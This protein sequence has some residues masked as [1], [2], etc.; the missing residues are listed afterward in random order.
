MTATAGRQGTFLAGSSEGLPE[1]V[2][3]E[4]GKVV[5]S[6]PATTAVPANDALTAGLDREEG[7]RETVETESTLEALAKEKLAYQMGVK[8]ELRN[9]PGL[10]HASEDV[11]NLAR[12][13]Y[14]GKQGLVVVTDRRVMF[15]SEGIGRHKLEDFPYDKVS[16]VQSEKG[17]VNGGLKIFAS[18]NCATRDFL[19]PMNSNRR[20]GSYSSGSSRPSNVRSLQSDQ[21]KPKALG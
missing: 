16:S 17:M 20:S 2:A 4:I 13:S 11:V 15:L 8:K 7:A 18:V 6:E 21:G 1:L 14:D 9:L 19:R 10:L 3:A 12:G 5:D